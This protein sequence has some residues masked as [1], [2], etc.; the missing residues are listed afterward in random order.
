[1]KINEEIEEYLEKQN[2]C[3]SNIRKNQIHIV[4][5]IFECLIKCRESENRIFL[6]GNGGSAS[7]ASHFTSD[8][9]K[10]AIT[11]DTKRFKAYSLTDNMPVVLAWAND[12][13]YDNIFQNQLENQIE[14]N[15]ILISLSGSGNSINII[16][17]NEYANKIL[18]HTIAFTGNDG[19]KLAKIAKISLV[20]PSD[21]MLTIE[22]MHLLICHLLITMIRKQGKPMFTY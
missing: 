15:D 14:K 11:K 13:S 16:K 6:I 4:E 18:A 3:V 19:G 5:E 8:L 9:L 20:I 17:A 2:D 12:L 7:T 10:T 22:S 1:M 21:D